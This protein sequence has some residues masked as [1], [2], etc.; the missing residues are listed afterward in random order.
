MG[1]TAQQERFI[2]EYI[3]CRKGAEAARRAGYS[4]K[5]AR[6]QASRL[7]TNADILKE[8][9]ERTKANAMDLDEALSRLADIARADFG[10]Y[11][12]DDGAIDIAAMKR[13]G[14]TRMLRKVKRVHKSGVNES[15]AEWEETF[16]EV[17][18]HDAK[19]AQK[20]IADLHKRGATGREDDPMHVKV[21]EGPRDVR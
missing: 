8:I 2:E 11:I 5:T 18:L 15:G 9:Q 12:T 21:I 10:D 17:E 6:T 3:K 16:V 20:F 1:I 19:D 13:I 14:A 7:L 4:V